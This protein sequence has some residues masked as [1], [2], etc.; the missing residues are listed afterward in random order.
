MSNDT[1][2]IIAAI[3]GPMV[4]AIACNDEVSFLTQAGI[5][6]LYCLYF[7]LSA[8]DWFFDL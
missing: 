6:A 3:L 2:L 1:C 8:V 4:Y 7:F 5:V